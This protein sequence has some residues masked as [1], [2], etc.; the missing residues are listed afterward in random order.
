MK[1]HKCGVEEGR[2]VRTY[3]WC[4]V[5]VQAVRAACRVVR[6]QQKGRQK[7]LLF[8]SSISNVHEEILTY[9][10]H[11]IAAVTHAYKVSC[12]I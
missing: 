12:Y 8:L 7:V 9:I 6:R 10:L 11:V 2:K 4:G 3:R 5:Q 1:V